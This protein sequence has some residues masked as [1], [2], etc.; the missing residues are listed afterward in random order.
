MQSGGDDPKLSTLTAGTRAHP[1][2]TLM[3]A[4][5]RGNEPI[6]AMLGPGW[7]KLGPSW[8]KLGQIGVRLGPV[9]AKLGPSWDK[10]GHIGPKLGSSWAQVGAKLRLVGAKLGQ[11]GDGGLPGPTKS[12]RAN[13]DPPK[14][15]I[16]AESGA[17]FKK[18]EKINFQK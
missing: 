6:G 17:K 9:G 3:N 4:I 8:A 2:V 14:K 12:P 18:Y 10:L 1:K 13:K 5:W 16:F 11:V 7:A 15:A